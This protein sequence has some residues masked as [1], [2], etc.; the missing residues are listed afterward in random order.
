[1]NFAVDDQPTLQG[2]LAVYY[3]VFEVL[4]ANSPLAV[5]VTGKW[6][7]VLPLDA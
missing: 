6:I 5:T 7:F 3:A 2:I 4:W 1:M